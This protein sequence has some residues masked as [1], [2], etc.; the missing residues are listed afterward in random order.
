MIAP[1]APTVPPD[2]VPTINSGTSASALLGNTFAYSITT[3]NGAT[4]YSLVSGSLLP[5]SP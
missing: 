1:A 3:L 4:S 2:S 5:D